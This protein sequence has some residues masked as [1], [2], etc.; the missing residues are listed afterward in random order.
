MLQIADESDKFAVNLLIKV[1]L[2]F[3]ILEIVRNSLIIRISS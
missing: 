3:E 2:L 1:S